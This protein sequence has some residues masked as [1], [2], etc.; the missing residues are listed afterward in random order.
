MK[1]HSSPTY[2]GAELFSALVFICAMSAA[3]MYTIC[4]SVVFETTCIMTALSFGIYMI[5]YALRKK[6]AYAFFA[7]LACFFVVTI[8]FSVFIRLSRVSPVYFIFRASEYYAATMAAAFIPLFSFMIGFPTAYFSVYLPRPAFL[9]LPAFIPLLLAAKTA[10]GLPAGYVVFMAVGYAL[11]ILGVSRPEFPKE[12]VYFDDKKSRF[13]RLGS[14]GIFGLVIAV[15]IYCVPRNTETPMGDYLDNAFKVRS[16]FFAGNNLS[17][18]T[19]TSS[20]NHGSNMLSENVLFYASADKPMIVS[21]WFFDEYNE[22]GHWTAHGDY[23]TGYA[24][25]KT[26]KQSLNTAVLSSKLRVAADEGQLS[27]YS[28][29]LKTL[30]KISEDTYYSSKIM[31]IYIADNSNTKVIIHPNMTVDVNIRG[32]DDRIYRTPMD[33]I[34][35]DRNFG[36]NASYSLSYYDQAPNNEL[37]SLF[38]QVDMEELLSAAEAEGVISI[39][40]KEAFINERDQAAEYHEKTLEEP[41][42][43]KIIELAHEITDGLSSDYEKALAIEKWFGEAKFVY[44]LDFIP[45]E[46][47]AEY[48]LFES[49]RG[50]C[51]DFA[52]AAA[53]LMRAADIPTR[54]GEG[55]VLDSDNLNE[56]GYYA[57]KAADAHAFA[58][59]YIEGY[60]WLEI[61]GTKYA[62]AADDVENN[63]VIPLILL[64]IAILLGTLAFIFRDKLSEVIFGVGIYF[65]S[66]RGKIR[67]VYLRTRKLACKIADKEPKSTTSEEVRGII[68]NSLML[69][70]EAEEITSC[71]DALFYNNTVDPRAGKLY[72]DYKKIVKM[73]RKMRK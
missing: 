35:T 72:A 56:Y 46:T 11:V 43:P 65:R 31:R 41:I 1:N 13:E 39:T 48:F 34:F 54:Y 57:V 62:I 67:A 9:L 66:D 28:D 42:S 32:Y 49:K 61:D 2:Q 17:N 73:K 21:R 14:L 23:T 5:F 24:N 10:N 15:V 36:Q 47:T 55:F 68:S 59:G 18:F 6:K 37:I 20:V 53:L 70:A 64:I 8:I 63:S 40:E 27:E 45:R 7:F 4:N 38:E 30:P 3:L 12:N 50:I 60:G 58:M 26:Y 16:T 19:N 51:T 52:S 71:A 33:E 22:D 44:D 69:G 25:W 29:L